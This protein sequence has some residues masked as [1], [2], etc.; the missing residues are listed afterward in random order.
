[1]KRKW[2]VI[3]VSLLI[4][5]LLG[6]LGVRAWLSGAAGCAR[7]LSAMEYDDPDERS[8]FAPEPTDAPREFSDSAYDETYLDLIEPSVESESSVLSQ[9]PF[10]E[11]IP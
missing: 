10:G 1:M 4:T 7:M 5:A 2:P 8:R 6:A 9:P 3:L 11:E